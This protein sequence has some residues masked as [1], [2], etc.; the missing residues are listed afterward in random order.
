M[1]L[2]G[3]RQDAITAADTLLNKWWPDPALLPR[4]AAGEL[5]TQKC[6]G[7]RDG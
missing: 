6:A 7:K 2:A 1:A 5:A 4:H 3:R